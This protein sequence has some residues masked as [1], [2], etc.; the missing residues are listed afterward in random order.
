MKRYF[1]LLIFP[2]I[3]LLGCSKLPLKES[4][5]AIQNILEET[6]DVIVL[7]SGEEVHETLIFYP[8]GLVDPH[9][10]LKWQDELITL[11]PSLRIVNVKMPS[12]LAVFGIQK[13]EMVLNQ[14]PDC[15]KWLV[16]GHSLGGAMATSFV[17]KHSNRIDALIYIASYPADDRLLDFEHSI[18]S[19]S[20]SN[21]GLSTP[22]NIND[23]KNLLPPAYTME[24][25]EDYPDNLSNKT[26]FFEIQGGNHAQFGDYG[27]QK[28]DGTAEISRTSQQDF[29]NQ[30]L[31]GLIERI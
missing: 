20:A 13:G 9:S 5:S 27:I 18:M 28:N 23:R 3:L 17:D 7:S 19:I 29:M 6:S 16:A 14:Y 25:L 11:H 26:L 4:L 31:L 1:I 15:P 12:N 24:N 30:L 10:Y 21:D 2:V 22:E 8:G